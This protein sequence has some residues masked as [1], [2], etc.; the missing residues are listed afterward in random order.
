[1]KRCDYF[2]KLVEN[3]LYDT[4][5]ECDEH[6][7]R[8]S[9]CSFDKRSYVNSISLMKSLPEPKYPAELHDLCLDAVNENKL[10]TSNVYS[11]VKE[12]FYRL[13]F[14][15]E[16][17]VPACCIIMLIVFIQINNTNDD[18]MGE[19]N[20]SRRLSKIR[21]EDSVKSDEVSAE[22]VKDFLARLEEF[23]KKHPVSKGNSNHSLDIR[24]VSDK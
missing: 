1:M 9:D 7:E 18:I 22:E 12:F 23:N 15:L 17:A 21:R 11:R 14:P 24:L 2:K 3:G 8:C 10:G 6:I 19:K 13:L 16:L 4:V 20:S 5:F